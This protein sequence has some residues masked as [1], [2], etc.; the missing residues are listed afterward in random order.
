[1]NDTPPLDTTLNQILSAHVRIRSDLRLQ[2]ERISVREQ[3][4]KSQLEECLAQRAK[5][6][7]QERALDTTEAL[8]RKMLGTNA[9]GG[10]GQLAIS[11]AIGGK[12]TAVENTKPP[13]AR[14]GP[15]RY[16]MF[17]ALRT[18]GSLT[19]HEIADATNLSE[20]R[21]RDQ[22]VSDLQLGFVAESGAEEKLS[23]TPAG[24][25]LLERF[26]AYQ[27]LRGK[28]LAQLG[29]ATDDADE[30]AETDSDEIGVQ[31]MPPSSLL[32]DTWKE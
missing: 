2:V 30:Q 32:N 12:D 29:D 15:Q 6:Q 19:R 21:V 13:R 18:L 22:M 14:I 4:L 31:T 9:A 1:M 23:L 8:Y 3:E 17:I 11:I 16:Q 10:V 7:E 25:S 26:E 24:L 5:I 20:K 28:K 27:K